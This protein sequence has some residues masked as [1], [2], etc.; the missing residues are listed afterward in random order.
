M[1]LTD[2]FHHKPHPHRTTIVVPEEELAF[3]KSLYCRDGVLQHTINT[4][5]YKLINELKRIQHEFSE[6]DSERYAIAVSGCTIILGT[7]ARSAPAKQ[8]TAGDDG[9]GI[10]SVSQPVAPASVITPDQSGSVAKRSRRTK[11]TE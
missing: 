2:P 10:A 7:A 8:A 5:L 9:R 4:L 6:Y 11:E 3:L 1:H